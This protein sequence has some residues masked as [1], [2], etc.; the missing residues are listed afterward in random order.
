MHRASEIEELKY[1]DGKINLAHARARKLIRQ[2]WRRAFG[3]ICQGCGVKMHFEAKMATHRHFATIEHIK[4]RGT[5]GDANSLD[6]I[7]CICHSCN[8]QKSLD[9]YWESKNGD[10]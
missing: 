2:A 9:D 7:S 8:N 5:G 4:A 10:K 6:N 1:W 3:D